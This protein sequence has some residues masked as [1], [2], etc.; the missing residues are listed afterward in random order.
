LDCKLDRRLQDL[1]PKKAEILFGT[2]A[3]LQ[4]RLLRQSPS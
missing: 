2:H 1:Q 4:V 3:G